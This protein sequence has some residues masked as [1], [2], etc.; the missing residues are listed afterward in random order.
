VV[1][2]RSTIN[3]AHEHESSTIDRRI[4]AQF[5]AGTILMYGFGDSQPS[6]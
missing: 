6:G 3:G 2:G 4:Q 5:G 1:P